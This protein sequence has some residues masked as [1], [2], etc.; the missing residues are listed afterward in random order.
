MA[1]ERKEINMLLRKYTDYRTRLG[2]GQ[3]FGITGLIGL[4][5]SG[6]LGNASALL[7]FMDESRVFDFLRGFLAGISG[8][9][10][11]LSLVFSV[12]ALITIRKTKTTD[13]I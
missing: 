12:A 2:L 1:A 4:V 7:L 3:L 11:G 10:L 6:T 13:N 9:L 5:A 8:S